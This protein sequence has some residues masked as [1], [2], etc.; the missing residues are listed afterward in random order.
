MFR[1]IKNIFIGLLSASRTGCFVESLAYNPEGQIKCVSLN[2]RS[3]QARPTL[4]KINSN[5]SFYSPFT[6]NVNKFD[7]SYNTVDDP[8]AQ[9]CVPD[10]LKNMNVKVF[11]LM[12]SVNETRFLVQHDFCECKCTL[13]ESVCNSKQK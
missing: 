7:G 2:N 12:L 11:N 3:N 6:V 13:N 8:Y 4:F 10:K 5:E 1:F 9:V